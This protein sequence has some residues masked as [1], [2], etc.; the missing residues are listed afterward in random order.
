[1]RILL[2]YSVPKLN[3]ENFVQSFVL[4]LQFQH[5]KWKKR[6]IWPIFFSN[7]RSS[8]LVKYHTKHTEIG[9]ATGHAGLRYQ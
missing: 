8:K 4:M 1:M 7:S 6:I 2:R 9:G 5:W 3:T